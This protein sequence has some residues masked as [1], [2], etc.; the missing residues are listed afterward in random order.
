MKKLK[1]LSGGGVVF[2]TS[3]YTEWRELFNSNL[4]YERGARLKI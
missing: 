4:S 1:N 3:Q 2:T